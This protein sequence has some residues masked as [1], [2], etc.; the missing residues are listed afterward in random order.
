MGRQKDH[1]RLLDDLNDE[2]RA[3]VH[4]R[5]YHH[6]GP[7]LALVGQLGSIREFPTIVLDEAQTNN[8]TI[9]AVLH[10]RC[11]AH[12]RAGPDHTPPSSVHAHL[13]PSPRT[14]GVSS[15]EFILPPS[16]PDLDTCP[17]RLDHASHLHLAGGTAFY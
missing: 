9:V 11:T 7:E 14:P 13:L 8:E 15:Q 5:I 6:D 3:A 2:D 10:I 12:P 1:A 17:P 4:W 16:I